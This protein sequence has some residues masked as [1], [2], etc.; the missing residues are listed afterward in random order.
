MEHFLD[1]SAHFIFLKRK[2]ISYCSNR[3]AIIFIDMVPSF[4]DSDVY[5]IES[6]SK[7]DIWLSLSVPQK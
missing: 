4:T 6:E 1:E 2:F 7:Q 3:I 5:K